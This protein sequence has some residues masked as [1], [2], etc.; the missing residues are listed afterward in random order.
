MTTLDESIWQDLIG[1]PFRD[2][3]RGPE[4]YDCYGLMLEMYRRRGIVIDDYRYS[5]DR[6]E[7]AD[8]F[9]N[10]LA[11]WQRCDIKPGATLLFREGGIP[12]HVGVAIDDD[13]FIHAA[14]SLGQVGIGF[15]SRG[16]RIRLIGAF[17]PLR[18]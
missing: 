12:G 17:E 13:R 18:D 10:G 1:L 7:R 5:A 8:L 11:K 6:G 16:W 9:I 14:S 4:S 2:R 3:A 15:L